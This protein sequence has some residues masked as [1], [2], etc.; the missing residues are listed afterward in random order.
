A[1]VKP[2]FWALVLAL[3][4]QPLQRYMLRAIPD[5]P[6]LDASITMTTIVFLVLIP[7]FLVVVAVAREAADIAR[8]LEQGNIRAAAAFDWI[9]AR[10]P[11]VTELMNRFGVELSEIRQG[12]SAAAVA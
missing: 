1:F 12:L 8:D 4:F 7:V 3:L 5:R 6:S 10:I 11:V 2:V 9:Q